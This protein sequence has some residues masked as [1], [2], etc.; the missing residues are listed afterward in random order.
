[1]DEKN[2]ECKEYHVPA[3]EKG[4][5][6]LE[7]LTSTGSKSLNQICKELPFSRTTVFS[8]LKNM[9]GLGYLENKDGVYGVTLKL[10][11]L[12]MRAQR[13]NPYSDRIL[14]ELYILRDELK[15]TIHFS[16]FIGNTSILLYKL[17]G[18]GVVQLL[19]FVGEL[20]P[21]HLSGGGK[22]ILAYLPK[23]H[24][25]AYLDGPLAVRTE[26]TISTPKEL[27]ETRQLIRCR[28]YALD[29]EEGELGV[30]CIG[31]PVFATEGV[32][33]G[34]LSVSMVKSY[35]TNQLRNTHIE[36]MMSAGER[37]SRKLGYSGPYP[38]LENQ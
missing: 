34:G 24:F 9:E 16:S 13:Q 3:L 6:I 18:P 27:T 15:C 2:K 33:Y 29:D 36:K 23:E 10:F 26:R 32:I 17:D 31:V 14:P 8:L 22:A 25:Q 7:H 35:I 1:M 19:S 12:G 28:G 37:L 4:L 5:T 11:S 38:K 30:F 20:K 21:L